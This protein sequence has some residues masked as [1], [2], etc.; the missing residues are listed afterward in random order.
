LAKPESVG[1]FA[2][3]MYEK[4]A[5]QNAETQVDTVVMYLVQFEG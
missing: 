3:P 2:T 1:T 5:R 4:L